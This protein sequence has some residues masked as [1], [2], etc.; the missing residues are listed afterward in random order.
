MFS[1]NTAMKRKISGLHH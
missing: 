1:I